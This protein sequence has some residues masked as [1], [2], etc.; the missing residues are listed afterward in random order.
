MFD[1]KYMFTDGQFTLVLWDMDFGSLIGP[2]DSKKT[3]K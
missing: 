2:T 3:F 1:D